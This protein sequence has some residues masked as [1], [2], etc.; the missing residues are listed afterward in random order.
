M[1]DTANNN[2]LKVEP[3]KPNEKG[4]AYNRRLRTTGRVPGIVYGL[5]QDPLM[6]TVDAVELHDILHVGNPLIHVAHGGKDELVLIKEVQHD[7]LGDAL[8]HVDFN[9][10][11]VN[12]KVRVPLALDYKGKPAGADQGGVLDVIVVEIEVECLPLDIPKEAFKV[13]VADLKL[14]DVLHVRELKLP[15]KLTAVTPADTVLATVKVPLVKAETPAEEGAAEP[16]VLKKGK[17]ET[18]EGAAADAK[19]AKPD[20]K[21][22]DKK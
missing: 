18:E 15:A 13:N 17:A 8:V 1:A 22:A 9:R 19:G 4:A 20:A 14:N 6:V 10:V 16:E 21:K 5:A 7:P 12:K 11:D 2:T 3:R